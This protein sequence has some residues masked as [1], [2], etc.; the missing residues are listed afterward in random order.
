MEIDTEQRERERE[1]QLSAV[2]WN[3]HPSNALLKN[4]KHRETSLRVV[5]FR[6]KVTK[7][8]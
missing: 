6:Y 1:K 2:S 3:C 8:E 7:A 4:I 5:L